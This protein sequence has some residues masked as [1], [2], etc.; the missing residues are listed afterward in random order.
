[1]IDLQASKADNDWR[2]AF[3]QAFD[4]CYECAKD[5]PHPIESVA[6]VLYAVEGENDDKTDWVA[7]VRMNDGRYAKVFA[8]CDYTGWD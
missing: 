6:Q 4:G 5:K 7:I 1:V 8:G 3:Q 2:C